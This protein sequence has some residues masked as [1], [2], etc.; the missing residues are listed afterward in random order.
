LDLHC[1]FAGDFVL[2]DQ[3]IA[4]KSQPSVSWAWEQ[5]ERCSFCSFL[6]KCS[7]LRDKTYRPPRSDGTGFEPRWLK[8]EKY[9]WFES[10]K[11]EVILRVV[12]SSPL[13][14]NT[15]VECF[16]IVNNIPIGC[17]ASEDNLSM[18]GQTGPIREISPYINSFEALRENIRGCEETH[19]C[20]LANAED[21]SDSSPVPTLVIE[22]ALR[23]VVSTPRGCRYLALSYVWGQS[24]K[25]SSVRSGEALSSLPQTIE[26]AITVTLKLGFQYLWVD[27]YCIDQD[28]EKVLSNS[29]RHMDLVYRKAQAT[30]IA[31]EGSDP[32]FGLPGVSSARETCQASVNLKGISLATFPQDPWKC[33]GR[34]PWNNRAWTFQE[35]LFSPRRIF[36]TGKQMIFNCSS[37]WQCETTKSTQPL[38]VVVDEIEHQGFKSHMLPPLWSPQNPGR[39]IYSLIEK[40][41]SRRLTFTGDILNAFMG[42]LHASEKLPSP[43]RHHWG[44]PILSP[45]NV[46]L[47]SFIYGLS[48]EMS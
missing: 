28:D 20:H 42:V 40:Y 15:A 38:N 2:E 46:A 36:F 4:R 26:D 17:S 25:P 22:C 13:L 32:S 10:G 33:V 5:T 11:E 37:G 41:S 35:S 18:E 1:I 6:E 23:Q 24:Q 7:T 31:A 45:D 39:V 8:R 21:L 34:S 30:I 27:M 48:W 16:N 3:L 43:V 44:V 29:I 12:F 19:S 9:E 47:E 14:D